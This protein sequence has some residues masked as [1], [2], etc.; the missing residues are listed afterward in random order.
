M[1]S[2]TAT[3]ESMPLSGVGLLGLV[4]AGMYDNPLT[5]YREYIQNAV[6][7]AAGSPISG[8]ERIE[9][10]IDSADRRIRILDNGPG[11]SREAAL[12]C[13]LPIG[14]SSK[15]LGND[16]GFRGIGRLAG[17]AFAQSVSFTTRT[18][19]DETA[20]R[21]TWHRAKLPE[22]HCTS[23]KLDDAILDCVE[24]ET[25]QCPDRPDHFFE[26]SVEGVA[27]HATGLLLNHD[28]VREFVGEVCPVPF[29]T[30]F[31]FAQ[32]AVGLFEGRQAPL[33]IHIELEGDTQ[34]IHRPF[35]TAVAHSDKKA[36]P[37]LEFEPVYLPSLDTDRVAAIGWIAHTSYIGAI[38]K[39]LGVRGFRARIGNIQIGDESIF[40]DLFAEMRFNRWCVG[41]LHILDP[42]IIP[43]G[44]R[45]YFEPGPHTRNLENQ[46][47][48]RLRQVASRCRQQSAYRNR[49]R[50]AFA[51]LGDIEDRHALATSG[52]LSPEQS[53]ELI[54]R[55]VEEVNEIR[56]S[57]D[58]I[59][60]A[61]NLTTKL[62]EV[63]QLLHCVEEGNVAAEFA[64]LHNYEITMCQRIF[65]SLAKHA[66]SAAAA[67]NLIE[68]VIADATEQATDKGGD[69]EENH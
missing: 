68:T 19:E 12:Q 39:E 51:Q 26:V 67:A 33:A 4:T 11:L 16:R 56:H 14:R 36:A 45:D 6:D 62:T 37:Y 61:G 31:P 69:E 29:S 65:D 42:R 9:L 53:A 13:L 38:P 57:L 55:A 66:P 18:M 1:I 30:E 44:R 28:I 60:L 5:I 10:A 25:L 17:L 20:T 22:L 2:L 40:D 43:N 24:I 21:V 35:Q 32:N 50:K 7:A 47:K 23:S 63:E 15:T 8:R 52:Y 59:N 49:N 3:Q 34:P 27:R 46:L 41:E 54:R 58:E 64:G 48:P